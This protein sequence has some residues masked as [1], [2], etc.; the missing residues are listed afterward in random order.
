S[1]RRVDGVPYQEGDFTYLPPAGLNGGDPYRPVYSK[2][3]NSSED[4]WSDLIALTQSLA[5][6]RFT[7]LVDTPT[8][9]ADYV[10]SVQAKVDV[11]QWMTWFAAEAL[12]GN[13]E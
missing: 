8:W 13:G 1:V 10:A 5:K 3:T 7:T 9:N 2:N 6:G 12:I 11:D 4:N